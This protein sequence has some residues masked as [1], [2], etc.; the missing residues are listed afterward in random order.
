MTTRISVVVAGLVV[1][2]AG[3]CKD[4]LTA[5]N[6]NDPDVIRV[7]QQPAAIEQAL[8]SGYQLCRNT[9]K[10]NDV[11]AQ[12]AVMAGENYSALNNFNMGPRDGIPRSPVLNNKSSSQS[13]GGTFSAWSRQGRLVANALKQLDALHEANGLALSTA[14]ADLRAR[15]LGF[16]NIGCNL[17][18]LSLVFDSAGIIDHTMPSDSV[19]PLAGYDQVNAAALAFLD[20]AI[21]MANT[22]GS[23]GAGGFPTAA[24]WFGG[25]SLGK[26]DFIKLARSLK[27][28][29]RADVARNKAER[30]AVDWAAV[31]ADAEAGISADFLVNIGGTTG[32][33]IGLQ[34]SQFHV[35]AA[36]AQ[37]TMMYNGFTDTGNGYATWL[38]TPILS[39]N[40]DFAVVTPDLRWPQGGTLAA[41]RLASPEPKNHRDFPYIQARGNWSPADPWGESWYSHHRYKYIRNNSQQG[42]YPDF[43]KAEVDLLAAE[44]YLRLGDMSKALTK[45]NVSRTKAVSGFGRCDEPERPRAGPVLHSARPDGA[46]LHDPGLRVDLRGVQVRMAHGNGVQPRRRLVL[47]DAWLGRPRHQHAA[48]LS[49][50]GR[51]A[52]CAVAA[53]LQHRWGWPWKCPQRYVQVLDSHEQQAVLQAVG[54]GWGGSGGARVLH[55]CAAGHLDGGRPV[56]AS[57]LKSPTGD[58]WSWVSDSVLESCDSRE[59]S[60][61]PTRRIWS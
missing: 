31:A 41:Q 17:G 55:L 8:G 6:F 52:G 25:A 13:L 50:P 39:R 20:S 33:T 48:L 37:L 28:R 60:P 9:E 43:L 21:A 10:G 16:F 46:E 40:G 5:K 1:V 7:F 29:F 56:S 32:W 58:G 38:A 15:A 42:P 23:D 61:E 53:V 35:E 59:P 57:P 54:G 12:F 2:V 19:P 51:R 11:T 26:S 24:S 45:I 18:W 49:G 34:S 44:A 47:R 14:A 36:W 27:A 3:A 22:A 30:A 4:P